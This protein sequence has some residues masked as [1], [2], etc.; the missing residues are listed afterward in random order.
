MV[1]SGQLGDEIGLFFSSSLL[2]SSF[3]LFC[4]FLCL[5]LYEKEPKEEKKKS[6]EE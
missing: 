4:L 5:F 6:K 3:L 2:F 1:G